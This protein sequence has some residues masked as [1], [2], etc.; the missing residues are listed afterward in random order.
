M[1]WKELIGIF[2]TLFGI[3]GIVYG[4]SRDKKGDNTEAGEQKGII[5][6]ELGYIKSGIEDIKAEQREQ[7]KINSEVYARLSAVEVSCKQAHK[8]L[9]QYDRKEERE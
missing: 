6:S 2:G 9:D 4:F 3:F 5:L 8:R 7:R 1:D